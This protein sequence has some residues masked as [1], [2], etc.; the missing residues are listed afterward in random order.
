MSLTDLAERL[1]IM[2]IQEQQNWCSAVDAC[3]IKKSMSDAGFRDALTISPDT[4]IKLTTLHQQAIVQRKLIK[5]AKKK[6]K[7]EKRVAKSKN[8][9]QTKFTLFKSN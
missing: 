7:K 1:S 5:E 2:T 9:N 3:L 6:A 4:S 8:K